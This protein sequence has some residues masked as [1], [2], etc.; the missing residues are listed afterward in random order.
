MS[1]SDREPDSESVVAKVVESIEESGQ[2]G[3][4]SAVLS[5]NFSVEQAVGGW[6][7]MVE[8]V[9]PGLV[10][11]VT[12]IIW[13]SLSTALVASLVAAGVTLVARLIQRTPVTQALGGLVGVLI[14][15]LWAR[16]TGRAENYYAGALLIN[17]AYLIPCLVSVLIKWPIVGLIVGL[18][19][20]RGLAGWRS[21]RDLYRRGRTGTW[22]LVAMFALRLAVKTPLYFMSEVAWLGTMHLVLGLPLYALT[23]WLVWR[24]MRGYVRQAF[25]G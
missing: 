14:G 25:R 20:G 1:R 17:V 23:L 8:S 2:A 22:L 4:F 3:K 7:G 18:V 11:V 5:E 21:D 19:S 13:E 15:V 10:F 9:A 24:L 16:T 6:R 12:W